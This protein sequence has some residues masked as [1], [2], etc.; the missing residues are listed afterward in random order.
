M[1]TIRTDRARETFIEMLAQ[2]CN[3]SEACRAANISRSAAYQWRDEDADFAAAWKDAEEAAA[4]RLEREAW[5]RAVDGTDKPV[6]F[7]GVITATYKEYSDRM[8]EILLK[9]HRPEKFVE[10]VRN[11]H[12]GKNGGPIQ[13][14]D[15]TTATLIEEAKRL[16]IDPASLGL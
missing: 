7:Q 4:D 3:V 14:E 6:T 2:T 10:R 11:E 13:T 1:K 8:L 12:T 5:R 15:V 9:A 16:G